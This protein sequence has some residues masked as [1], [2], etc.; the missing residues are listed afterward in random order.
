MS[1]RDRRILVYR[2]GSLGDFVVALPALWAVR[3]RYPDAHLT[4]VRDGDHRLSRP[5]DIALLL[6]TLAALLRER[7]S[8]SGP[9]PG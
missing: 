5:A 9:L 4:L 1:R 3:E 2:V 8:Q 7:P 6:D